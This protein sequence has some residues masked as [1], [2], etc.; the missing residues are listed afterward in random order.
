MLYMEDAMCSHGNYQIIEE[1]M[2]EE[3]WEEGDLCTMKTFDWVLCG[4]CGDDFACN[5]R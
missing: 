1:D 5:V 3:V 4:L 2:V